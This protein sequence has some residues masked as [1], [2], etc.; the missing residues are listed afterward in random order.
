[1]FVFSF[2]VKKGA[3]GKAFKKIKYF[4]SQWVSFYENEICDLIERKTNKIL[5]MH[6]LFMI[7][8]YDTFQIVVWSFDPRFSNISNYPLSSFVTEYFAYYQMYY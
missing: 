7:V 2:R 3:F 4:I 1:M 5:L 6:Q 8:K